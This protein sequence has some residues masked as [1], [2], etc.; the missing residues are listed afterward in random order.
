MKSGYNVGVAF[1]IAATKKRTGKTVKR[2]TTCGARSGPTPSREYGCQGV[3]D[4]SLPTRPERYE[5]IN[6][7]EDLKVKEKRM[8]L[9]PAKSPAPRWTRR[10]LVR[11][12]RRNQE[13]SGCSY[14][15]PLALGFLRG[16]LH[17]A[18]SSAVPAEKII[19]FGRAGKQLRLV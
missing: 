5:G 7:G 3:G 17:R 6:R 2:G 11:C 18:C 10:N 13:C 14:F 15:K 9:T 8:L 19:W 1:A 12:S 16:A 4:T